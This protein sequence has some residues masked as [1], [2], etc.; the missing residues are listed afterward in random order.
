MGWAGVF[1]VS[2]VRSKTSDTRW[3]PEKVM[4][5]EASVTACQQALRRLDEAKQSG[6][7]PA[8]QL[9]L[10]YAYGRASRFS[11]QT[12]GIQ[13][14]V[15][16]TILQHR[17]TFGISAA[18]CRPPSASPTKVEIDTRAYDDREIG[19]GMGQN[20]ELLHRV[21]LMVGL[22]HQFEQTT[23]EAV[24]LIRENL[25]EQGQ[26]VDDKFTDI[27]NRIRRQ[28]RQNQFLESKRILP[29]RI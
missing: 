9:V 29:L 19:W 12:A 16:R 25:T 17:C 27:V 13:D 24:R 1:P 10:A 4:A 28:E 5:W 2:T 18:H 6:Q 15:H 3:S 23:R 8:Q 20:A 14:T 7:Q 21:R 11:E 26:T 22:A